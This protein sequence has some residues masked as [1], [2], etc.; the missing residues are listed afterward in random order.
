MAGTVFHGTYRN[1]IILA[2]PNTQNPAT[3]AASGYVTGSSFGV[4][5]KSP[6]AWNL[7]NLGRIKSTATGTGIYLQHGGN[8]TN[9]SIRSSAASITAAGGTAIAIDHGAG[10][11]TNFGTIE[12]S[13]PTRVAVYLSGGS[14]LNGRSGSARALIESPSNA[15]L[16]RSAAG[17]VANFGTIESTGRYSAIYLGAGGT[18]DNQGVVR[19]VG[20]A[21]VSLGR[22]GKVINGRSAAAGGLISAKSSAVLVTNRAGT[23]TNFGSIA[24][25]TTVLSGGS[26]HSAGVVLAAGGTL[27]NGAAGDTDALVTAAEGCVYAGGIGGAAKTGA[28]GS[29]VNYGTIRS[30][31]RGSVGATAILMVS[32][33]RVINHGRIESAAQSAVAFRNKAGT[34]TNFGT[35]AGTAAGAAIDLEKGGIVTNVHGGRITAGG[36]AS[37]V[38]CF[39]AAGTI[40]NFGLIA[41][42]GFGGVYFGA[43]GAVANHGTIETQA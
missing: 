35:I 4:L 36:S 9:G 13:T 5:G 6:V 26:L 15:V 23:I 30:T 8:I 38:A 37:A 19:G 33:G 39:G 17:S 11:L 28:V 24:S 18:L 40:A 21:A 16:M 27:V 12:N 43:G 2:N 41:N 31:G 14:V 10:K 32:G 7:T 22:G 29:V 25:T 1:G 42:A 34:V 20:G 3:I